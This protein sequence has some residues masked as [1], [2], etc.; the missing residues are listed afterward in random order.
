MVWACPNEHSLLNDRQFP[1]IAHTYFGVKQTCLE[2]LTRLPI[3]Q[4]AGGGREDMVTK[5]NPYGENLA[6]TALPGNGWTYHHD[7]INVQIQNI[8]KQSTL[9]SDTEIA[10]NFMRKLK[11][12]AV[13]QAA[14][15]PLL[16]NNQ[17]KGQVPDNAKQGLLRISILLEWINL[18]SLK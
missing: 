16:M 11:E 7:A 13:Q 8:A 14:H 15:L 10:Y 3:R 4:K 6:K 18:L 2:E 1:V 12:S 17:L 9:A 5:C